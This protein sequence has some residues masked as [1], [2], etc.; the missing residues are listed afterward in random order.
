LLDTQIFGAQLKQ[1]GF[2]FFSG[3][4]CSFLKNLINFA[5]NHCEYIIANNEGDAVAICAGAY[6]GGKKPVFLCQNSGL[7]NAVSPLTS[8]N[9][10]FKIPVLGFVSLRGEPGL[11]DE[12]QHELMGQITTAML[13]VMQ[14]KWE[15]LSG[16]PNEA[17]NQLKIADSLIKNHESFFLVV[18]KGTFSEEKLLPQSPLTSANLH[19]VEKTGDDSFPSREDVLRCVSENKDRDTLVFATTGKTGRELYEIEDAPNNFY[20]VGSMGCIS[21]LALGLALTKK[22]KKVIAIDGDGSV[23]MRLGVLTTNGYYSPSNM[24]HLIIDNNSYDSTGGQLTISHNVDFIQLAAASGYRDVFYIHDLAELEYR[25]QN[26]RNSGGLTL[27]YLKVAK[28]AKENL[29][30]PKI[31]PY[32]VKDRIM[33]FMNS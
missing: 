16:D 10:I 30:R 24:L 19:R 13:E 28:G 2:T 17:L 21:P 14:I 22:D 23:L 25:I 4:P 11:P 18:R 27:L 8:L 32:E 3:V 29:G 7:T 12:P 9:Q 15:Y 1:S 6:L 20:M 5:I 26:W 31:K 33:Q